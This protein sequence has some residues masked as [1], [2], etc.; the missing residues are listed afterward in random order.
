MES[1]AALMTAMYNFKLVF[2]TILLTFC[3]IR[4]LFCSDTDLLLDYHCIFTC[5][6]SHQPTRGKEDAG[7]LRE[8]RVADGR[9]MTGLPQ[10]T[11][12][13]SCTLVRKLNVLKNHG[14]AGRGS[15][16]RLTAP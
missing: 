13:V 16:A 1:T 5:F 2:I 14:G 12:P 3:L 7:S 6:S 4:F 11:T 9:T 10:R 8:F 15:V